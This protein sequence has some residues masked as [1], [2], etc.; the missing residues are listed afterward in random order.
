MGTRIGNINDVISGQVDPLKVESEK[1][2]VAKETQTR[3]TSG[4]EGILGDF[5][6]AA[7]GLPGRV[8][9]EK[10]IQ[11]RPADEGLLRSANK[12]NPDSFFGATKKTGLQMLGGLERLEN[13]LAGGAFELQDIKGPNLLNRFVKGTVEGAKG[14]R[15]VEFGDLVTSR[16]GDDVAKY[17]IAGI[18]AREAMASIGGLT[19][20]AGAT[21]GL[22]NSVKQALQGGSNTLQKVKNSWNL[23]N[24]T[25]DEAGAQISNLFDDSF[26][27][28]VKLGIGSKPVNQGALSVILN[29]VP[30]AGMDAIKRRAKEYGVV[31]DQ[32]TGTIQNTAKNVWKFRMAIDDFISPKAFTERATKNTIKVYKQVRTGL[33]GVL[34]N[35]DNQVGPLMQKYSDYA[36]N[37]WNVKD[38]IVDS[39]GRVV[40][41]RLV[42]ILKR[43][44]EP[45]YQEL[46]KT[47][48]KLFPKGNDMLSGA[49]Q[50]G[51]RRGLTNLAIQGAKAGVIGGLAINAIKKPLESM[52]GIQHGSA[53]GN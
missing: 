42:E 26:T 3:T 33:K 18:D 45:A 6:K 22:Y 2:Q 16:L 9:A 31:F 4:S 8:Q 29:K 7:F 48:A 43:D 38:K 51:R 14:D 15:R 28:G 34:E 36:D 53:E 23:A 35:V 32:T 40:V 24:K 47:Y 27:K 37:L 10:N 39:R 19:L 12:L 49:I 21:L 13:T 20:Q 30:K 25:L 1:I 11:A 44:G 17:E 46:L 41:N 52:A 5:D 50:L